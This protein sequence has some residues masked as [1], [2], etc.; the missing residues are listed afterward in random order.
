MIQTTRKGKKMIEGKGKI[1]GGDL[2]VVDTL[3]K[4]EMEG[5]SI[6]TKRP[7]KKPYC[8]QHQKEW[9]EERRGEFGIFGSQM[10]EEEAKKEFE[11]FGCLV[12]E[13]GKCVVCKRNAKKEL[14]KTVLKGAER[15]IPARYRN[16]APM[17]FVAHGEGMTKEE[18]EEEERRQD[19]ERKEQEATER[20]HRLSRNELIQGTFSDLVENFLNLPVEECE[21]PE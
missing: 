15:K 3:E 16:I 20:E 8:P 7:K 4:A 11:E 6:E 19:E 14:R 12:E 9:M 21:V 2:S 17:P 13:T 5:G 1:Q 10:S 18:R